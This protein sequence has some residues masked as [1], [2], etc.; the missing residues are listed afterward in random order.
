MIG[1][2][3]RYFQIARCFRDEDL[4]ADRQPEFTQLDLEMSFPTQEAIFGVIEQVMVRACAVAGIEVKA[5]FRHMEYREAIRRYGIDK[6]DLRFGMELREVTEQ[7]AEAREKL[8]LEGSVQAIVAPGAAGFSR[9]QVDELGGAGQEPGRARALHD[10]GDGGGREFG[11]GENAGR[12][13]GAEYRHGDGSQG[14]GPNRGCF[15]GRA[16]SGNR[17]RGVD[18]RSIAAGDGRAAEP[19]TEKSLG[20]FVAD[21]LP[22]LRVGQ[23]R[24]A[25]GAGAASLYRA[26]ARRTWTSWSPRRRRCVPRATTWC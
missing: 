23:Q 19:D 4:R 8:H 18:R 22:A 24:K 15:G 13:G 21:G 7:F 11:A 17:C 20:V 25:L 16:D 3:D 12:G 26:S 6:P 2:L 1:G 10:Q 5:P 9:K 14:R